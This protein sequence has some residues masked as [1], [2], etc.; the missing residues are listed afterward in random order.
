LEEVDFV[1]GADVMEELVRLVKS[2]KWLDEMEEVV[3]LVKNAEL[4][5]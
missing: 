2:G 4:K 3:E 5:E 1:R